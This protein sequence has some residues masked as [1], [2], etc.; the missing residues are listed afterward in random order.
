MAFSK[1]K[2]ANL[3]NSGLANVRAAYETRKTKE[4]RLVRLNLTLEMTT[5]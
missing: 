5:H 3:R 4:N 2:K 1:R